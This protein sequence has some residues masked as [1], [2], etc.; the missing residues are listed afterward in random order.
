MINLDG[1][2]GGGQVLRTALA[3]SALTGEPFRIVNIRAARPQP[4]LKPQHYTCVKALQELTNAKTDAQ[5]G[6]TE[7]MFM[8]ENY[9]AQNK[10]IDIG[11]AGSITLL[12]QSI[13]LPA[14]FSTKTHTLTIKGGTDVQWSMPIDYFANV[15][16]P[17]LRRYAGFELK[18]LKRGYYPKG[19]GEI[20]LKIVP[21]F[22]LNNKMTLQQICEQMRPIEITETG[23]LMM[24]KGISHASRD[25][26]KQQVAERQ[27]KAAKQLFEHMDIEVQYHDT[28]ST[29]SG[30]VLWAMYSKDG[31]EI[32]F[33]NP[34][35]VGADALGERGKS[36]E[37]VGQ[38]AAQK[39]KRLIE[40]KVP[41]DEH[42]ADNL[43]PFL[44]LARGSEI[45]TND[46]T[47]HIKTNITVTE[48][49]LG[50]CIKVRE[51]TIES[52]K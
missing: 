45:K 47:Q 12:L 4:G 37:D 50:K 1:A 11:T 20:E 19:G 25:L 27:A 5:L 28:L 30:I 17:Q 51:N 16:L 52:Y 26:E 13:I 32:D 8:P 9:K 22:K 7:L 10:E 29:G 44:A 23:K 48:A 41:V 21:R 24:I 2:E 40:A 34:V 3:L 33:G 39:L 49:F 15:L 6:G 18:I 38:E 46:I 43:I 36:A 42:L 31:E 35:I 14:M